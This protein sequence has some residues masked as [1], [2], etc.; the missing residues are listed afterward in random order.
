MSFLKKIFGT[1]N[2]EEQESKKIK[3]TIQTLKFDGLKALKMGKIDHAEAFFNKVL[4]Y[5]EDDIDALLHLSQIYIRT[6]ELDVAKQHMTKVAELAPQ[7][8]EA[9]LNLAQ[10]CQ[11]KKDYLEMLN[12][13]NEAITIDS[14]N[15]IAHYLQGVA[16]YGQK[17]KFNAIASLTRAIAINNYYTEALLLRA[18]ILISMQEYNEAIK[19]LNQIME[20]E[21]DQEDDRKRTRKR[22][23][24]KKKSCKD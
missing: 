16:Y 1:K 24:T 15:A 2:P 19:D 20:R 7:L 18:K 3:N 5:N 22:G 23:K 21:K 9:K 10:I 8:I 14:E 13:A 4:E 12:A 6:H 11:F 17:D